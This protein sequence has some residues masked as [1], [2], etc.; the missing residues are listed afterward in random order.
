ML[1][2]LLKAPNQA[3]KFVHPYEA[4]VNLVYRQIVM[5]EFLTGNVWYVNE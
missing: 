5:F 4:Q 1:P 3:I 2:D